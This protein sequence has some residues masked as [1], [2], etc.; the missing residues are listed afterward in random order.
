MKQNYVRCL[1]NRPHPQL[2]T[3]D[4]SRRAYLWANPPRSGKNVLVDR[5]LR[6]AEKTIMFGPRYSRPWAP[7][8]LTGRTPFK[9]VAESMGK[10]NALYTRR[11]TSFL[12]EMSYAEAEKRIERLWSSVLR[13]GG[14]WD[15]REL[16][17]NEFG[18]GL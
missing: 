12:Q 18:G 10:H 2:L 7:F 3:Y 8:Q 17:D 5:L 15:A 1:L 14:V 6:L 13:P 9:D 16:R 11:D 4:Q